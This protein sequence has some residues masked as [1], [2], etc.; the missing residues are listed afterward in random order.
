MEYLDTMKTQVVSMTNRKGP[1]WGRGNLME[2]PGTIV[3]QVGGL[4]GG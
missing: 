1:V 4:R 2:Y 3:T